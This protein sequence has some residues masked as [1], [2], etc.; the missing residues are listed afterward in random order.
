M[1]KDTQAVL[2]FASISGKK[3]EADFNGGMTTSDGGVLLLR[4]LESRIGIVD[5]IVESLWDRRHQS[6]VDHSY[7]D[8]I[9][10]RVLQIACGYEDANDSD[11]LRCDPGMKAACDRLP[12]T[13]ADLAS[14]P[15]IS[16]LENDVSRTDLYR[17][18]RAFVDA[19]INSYDKPPKKIVLDI[20]DTDDPTHGSQQLCLFNAHVGEYCYMPLHIYEGETG[21]LVTSVLRPGK[22][23]SG[24]QAARILKRVIE[25]IRRAWPKTRI[26]LRGDSH[27]SAPQIQGPVRRTRGRVHSGPSR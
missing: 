25:P 15:T 12:I 5:R 16:R 18:G 20:D 26:C 10:Q 24:S 11:D 13:G 19:F 7:T 2:S 4:E 17:V 9:R 3:I 1:T 21:K 14:Q 8:L 22:R 6:Y 23:I 27:F